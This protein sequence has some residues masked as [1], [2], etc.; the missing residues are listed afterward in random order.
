MDNNKKNNAQ[1]T[2]NNMKKSDKTEFSDE[3]NLDNKNNKSS[4][5]S[6]NK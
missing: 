4:N 1:D 5:A 3:I 6:N 2:A